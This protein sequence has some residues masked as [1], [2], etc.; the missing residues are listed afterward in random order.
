MV[1]EGNTGICVYR[2]VTNNQLNVSACLILENGL[3]SDYDVMYL[4]MVHTLIHSGWNVFFLP[5]LSN[6]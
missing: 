6:I 2:Y 5:Q 3:C 1:T 4:Q